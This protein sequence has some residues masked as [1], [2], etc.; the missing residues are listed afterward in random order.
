MT[1]RLSTYIIQGSGGVFI[2]ESEWGHEYGDFF[3]VCACV[4]CKVLQRLAPLVATYI[5]EIILFCL[6]KEAKNQPSNRCIHLQGH[7]SCYDQIIL[8]CIMHLRLIKV[9]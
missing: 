1:E 8:L 4:I 6:L 3:S 2:Y 5:Q 7:Q 9:S